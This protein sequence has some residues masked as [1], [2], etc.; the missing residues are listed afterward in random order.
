MKKII[1]L[2][3]AGLLSAGSYA[4][5]LVA[6]YDFNNI[7]SIVVPDMTGNGLTGDL[8][9]AIIPTAGM[10]GVPNTAIQFDGATTA[11][12][13][14]AN[15][16]LDLKRWTL[17]VT[18]KFNQ[19]NYN[20][21]DCQVVKLLERGGQGSNQYYSLET[22]DNNIDNSCSV[23]TPGGHQFFG[24][25]A[26]TGPAYNSYPTIPTL[27]VGK[28]YCLTATY[29]GDT[30][31]GYIDGNLIYAKKWANQYPNY[32]SAAHLYIG[33]SGT[34]VNKY[35][36][37]GIMDDC[38]IWDGALSPAQI[39]TMCGTVPPTVYGP[40]AI[41]DISIC[42]ARSTPF[43]YTFTPTTTVVTGMAP[44]ALTWHW[45]DG[46]PNGGSVGNAPVSHTFPAGGGTYYVCATAQSPCRPV[47]EKC[48]QV[49][50]SSDGAKL[51]PVKTPKQHA[52]DKGQ[53]ITFETSVGSPYPSPT[54]SL[55]NIPVKR[56]NGV[57]QVTITGI[58]G[59]PELAQTM[60]VTEADGLLQLSTYQLKPGVY[61]LRISQGDKQ[62]IRRFTKQ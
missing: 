1:G 51:S 35:R 36:F 55:L 27:S 48:F 14:I 45:G 26:G 3:A 58:N 8:T 34:M 17:S 40:C 13:V 57:L 6:H 28:W 33:L 62:V 4:Q 59:S 50:L 22:N 53:P 31:K 15:P 12:R 41:N 39:S 61:L 44:V 18:V 49:C 24:M 10:N 46:T 20:P 21:T 60:A 23:A 29:D 32:G 43:K 30:L 19:F 9:G 38:Q 37:N 42:S 16:Q 52:S 54:N 5:T 25:A 47:L 2:L 56:L 7:T 11:V